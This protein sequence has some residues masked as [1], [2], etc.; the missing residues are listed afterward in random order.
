M[1]VGEPGYSGHVCEQCGGRLVT[2]YTDSRPGER[3]FSDICTACA[4]TDHWTEAEDNH[5][6]PAV[7]E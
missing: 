4:W 1:S 2:S 5:Q 7:E 6:P 3:D